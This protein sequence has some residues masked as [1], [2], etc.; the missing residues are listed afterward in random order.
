MHIDDYGRRMIRV[1]T[2]TVATQAVLGR[3]DEE[4]AF[5]DEYAQ[6]TG[7][8]S[9]AP[10]S[11]ADESVFLAPGDV[12]PLS[13]YVTEVFAHDYNLFSLGSSR[14]VQLGRFQ[15]KGSGRNALAVREDW[16]HSWGGLTLEEGL[17]EYFTSALLG[18]DTVKIAGVFRYEDQPQSYLLVRDFSLPRLATIPLRV[19][20][21]KAR[22]HLAHTILAHEGK[23]DG[24]EL[25]QSVLARWER[26][27]KQGLLMPAFSVANIDVVGRLLDLHGAFLLPIKS[28]P[29]FLLSN[30]PGRPPIGLGDQLFWV[31]EN[32]LATLYANLFDLNA[33]QLVEEA[34]SW[35]N[36]NNFWG[37]TQKSEE[38]SLVRT[39]VVVTAPV[40]KLALINSSVKQRL[41][42]L[43]PAIEGKNTEE[44]SRLVE[45]EIA[46]FLHA[47]EGT[48]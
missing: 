43:L 40:D 7:S 47:R 35:M 31:A 16:T 44:A 18:E 32:F 20:T 14:H 10:Q 8:L 48:R 12:R 9:L 41:Q 23:A 42:N 30:E 4:K 17:A 26:L 2:R 36:K 37:R 6:Q 11:L 45:T 15:W 38:M 39:G 5:W 34:R 46:S 21:Q 33:H 28:A 29:T 27:I 13:T 3:W 19:S 1:P 25:W 22:Q 24:R